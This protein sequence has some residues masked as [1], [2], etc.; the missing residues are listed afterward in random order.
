MN[1]Q[2]CKIRPQILSINSDNPLFYLYSI[3][4]YTWS[5]CCNNI[6]DP[7]AKWYLS[8]VVKNINGKV[9]NLMSK[10]LMKQDI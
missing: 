10:T 2:D 6:N 9:F 3:Q 7:Y 8:D 5:G 1:N 4:V